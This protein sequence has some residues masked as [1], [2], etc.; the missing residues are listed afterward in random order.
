MA[1]NDSLEL[2]NFEILTRDTIPRPGEI[3]KISGFDIYG[4]SIP[5]RGTVGGDHIIYLDFKNRYDL[6]EE[7]KEVLQDERFTPET[8]ERIIANI[9]SLKSKAGLLIA[10]VSG[11]YKTDFSFASRLHDS[12]LTGV[13]YEI[14]G[15]GDVTP[16]LFRKLNTRLYNSSSFDKYITMIYGEIS[17]TGIFKFISAGHPFPLIYSKNQQR[18]LPSA[19]PG[20]EPSPPLAAFPSSGPDLERKMFR[21]GFY[22]KFKVNQMMIEEPGDILLLYTDGITEHKNAEGKFFYDSE[23]GGELEKTI[24]RNRDLSSKDLFARIKESLLEFSE[25]QD[26]VSYILIKK[27]E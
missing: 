3:P 25:P 9:H 2:D 24:H 27:V 11:H 12:F 7:I 6:E 18:L 26:D 14:E 19:D 15:R 16:N 1:P 10:D 4:E 22:S 17:E 5:I 23:S 13:L 21:S 8:K 20:M